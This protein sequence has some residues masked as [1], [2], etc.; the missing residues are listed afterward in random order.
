[1]KLKFKLGVLAGVLLSQY[2]LSDTSGY[3]GA[4]GAGYSNSSSFGKIVADDGRYVYNSFLSSLSA[5][6]RFEDD[7]A[8]ELN[9]V[10]K[11]PFQRER[12]PQLTQYRINVLYYLGEDRL[13]WYA[14]IG[15]GY[16]EFSS[17]S[18]AVVD[19]SGFVWGGGF[20]VEYSINNDW[21]VRS[22]LR[23]D[24]LYDDSRTDDSDNDSDSYEYLN[25]LIE[26]GYNFGNSS[27]YKRGFNKNND[28]DRDGVR[29]SLDLC[30]ETPKGVKVNSSGC[31]VFEGR[32]DGIR[33]DSGSAELKN[34]SKKALD[35][36][37]GELKKHQKVR[38]FIQAY[39]DSIGNEKANL[40]L[41]RDRARSVRN[42]LVNR[43]VKSSR[44]TYEG[45][46]E[47]QPV[48]TNKTPEGRALN[49]RVVF[50]VTE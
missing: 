22:G 15:A 48:A 11:F 21:F 43:G 39:T 2:V 19:Y 26:I 41:S 38:I 3:Y 27:E 20:G 32:L 28:A 10:F 5:G 50:R 17:P 7:L 35:K 49:R 33:F 44:I 8:M 13:K 36:I 30:P 1:M 25:A 24:Q 14:M 23:L 4:M 18:P 40:K 34:D 37:S 16:G 6:Y 31:A 12:L 47:A 29:D 42:Y 9:G 45:Y 46:G